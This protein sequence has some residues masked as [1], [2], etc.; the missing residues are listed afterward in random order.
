MIGHLLLQDGVEANLG[1]AGPS[2]DALPLNQSWRRYGKHVVASAVAA[3]FEQ[4]RYIEYSERL[5]PRSSTI[6]KA[7]LP[8]SD[9][10]VKDA[11]EPLQRGYITKDPL[12]EE[13]P[14][15]SASLGKHTRKGSRYLLNSAAT[16]RQ[17]SM[18]HPIGIK[19][20]NPELPQHRRGGAFPHADGARKTEDD[21]CEGTK[22]A[23]IAARSR[24]VIRTGAPN[25]AS[26][27]G[28]P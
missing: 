4:E 27:P 3:G 11:F 24:G 20:R 25:Q 13:R 19:Q 8:G 9:H 14:I 2:Q 10:R 6:K 15:N 21:Q 22:V 17:Q 28:R 12:A 5:S 26:N 18:H 1:H 7:L 16:G 23:T